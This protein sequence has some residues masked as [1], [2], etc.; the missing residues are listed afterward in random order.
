MSTLNGIIL[1]TCTCIKV[2][3]QT[4][5]NIEVLKIDLDIVQDIES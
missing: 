1:S 5:A 2:N 4:L 3:G